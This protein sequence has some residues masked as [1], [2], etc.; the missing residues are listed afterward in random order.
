M[1][2]AT[3]GGPS[4]MV[5]DMRFSEQGNNAMLNAA[6]THSLSRL[7]LVG[8]GREMTWKV[9]I[10]NQPSGV[11]DFAPLL[12]RLFQDAPMAFQIYGADGRCVLSNAAFHRMF[13][14][15]VTLE[16]DGGADDSVERRSLRDAIQRAFA[17]ETVRVA[18]ENRETL[19]ANPSDEGMASGVVD[20]TAFPLRDHEHI[21]RHV[22]ICFQRPAPEIRRGSEKL[23]IDEER[24]KSNER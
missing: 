18:V 5:S 24:Q 17:G 7:A 14:A 11:V 4:G 16:R 23:R 13:A 15:N 9:S 12:E 2:E 22:A 3:E 20:A 10:A 6:S 21:V 8:G 1:T 19:G